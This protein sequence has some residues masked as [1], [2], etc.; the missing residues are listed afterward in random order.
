MFG[1]FTVDFISYKKNNENKCWVIDVDPFINDNTSSY[2][3]FDLLMEG[4]FF[5]E[6][7][8]YLI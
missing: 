5:P 6:K 8:L 7:N 3:I 1:N 2:Y 4:S